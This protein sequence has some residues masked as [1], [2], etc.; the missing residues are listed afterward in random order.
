RRDLRTGAGIE[1]DHLDRRIVDLRQRGDRQLGDRDQP[2]EQD[3]GHHQRRRDRAQDERAGWA[4]RTAPPDPPAPVEPVEPAGAA[5]PAAGPAIVTGAPSRSLSK[6]L[7][8]TTAPGATPVIWVSS[9]A[10]APGVTPRRWTRPSSTTYTNARSALR[11]IAA[12]GTA[13]APRSV[14]TRSRAVPNWLGNS[15]SSALSTRARSRTVP[16]VVSIWLSIAISCP[17]AS[18]RACTRS[19][20]S[21]GRPAPWS[22]CARTSPRSSSEIANTTLIGWSCVITASTGPVLA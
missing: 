12:D 2:G 1:R 4:H 19:S 7:I 14:V 8:A 10:T 3:R 13:V 6:L 5:E 16:V 15:A 17:L 21:T 9:P 20:A 18:R 22:G 11:W